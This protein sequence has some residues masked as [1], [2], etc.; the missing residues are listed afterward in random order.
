MQHVPPIFKQLTGQ[1]N[2][3]V[4]SQ[5]SVSIGQ[6]MQLTGQNL[7]NEQCVRG[8]INFKGSDSS[9]LS[10]YLLFCEQGKTTNLNQGF[11]NG[12]DKIE[13]VVPLRYKRIPVKIS[14]AKALCLIV[15]FMRIL[16]VFT[17]Q[18][19]QEVQVV[20][21]THAVVNTAEVS[22]IKAK[23]LSHTGNI[24]IKLITIKLHHSQ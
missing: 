23:L 10:I 1:N 16:V 24:R 8:D 13:N 7:H 9:D 20:K 5:S 3:G 19:V 22:L 21:S 6:K 14:K 2:G 18:F 17:Q 12:I 4:A 15:F 11:S